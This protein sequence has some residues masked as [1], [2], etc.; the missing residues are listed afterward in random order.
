MS[1]KICNTITII[2]AGSIGCYVGGRLAAAGAKVN[3]IG[4]TRIGDAIKTHGLHVTD[5]LGYDQ[6]LSL[7]DTLTFTESLDSAA[8]ADLILVCVK[9]AATA[10]VAQDLAKLIPPSTVVISLQNGL[11]NAA[12]LREHLPN[13]TCLAGM[14]QFNVI[15]RGDGKFH[16]GSEGGLECEAHEATAPFMPLFDACGLGL[17]Q[18]QDFL[19]VQ[20]AKLLLNLNNPIN[21]LSGVPLKEE[22]SQRDFRR[23]LAAAQ[24]EAIGLLNHA[25]IK[26]A[27]LTS[28]PPH[29]IPTL[30]TV[31]TWLFKLLANKMLAIDPLARSSMWEDLEAGRKTEI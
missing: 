23:C 8:N 18:P 27:K 16:Q 30:L 7:S 26:P 9:S 4:R 5:Y 3:L 13:N 31:P 15:N 14:V 24:A 19:A 1:D 11:N 22:L 2:G 17:E 10:E 21:A 20:W 28:L 25:N 6:Q 12:V 29:W